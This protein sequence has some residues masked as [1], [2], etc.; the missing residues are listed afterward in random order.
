MT[1]ELEELIR[2]QMRGN[3][4][5]TQEQAEKLTKLVHGLPYQNTFQ[6]DVRKI[7]EA[8]ISLMY[9]QMVM[10]SYMDNIVRLIAKRRQEFMEGHAVSTDEIRKDVEALLNKNSYIQWTKRT[11]DEQA[12]DVEKADE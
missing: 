9:E 6:Y 12:K 8:V 10:Y 11:L 2:Q 4:S 7:G 1:E 3:F 5:R